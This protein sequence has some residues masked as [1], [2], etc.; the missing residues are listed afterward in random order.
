[1]SENYLRVKK[2]REYRNLAEFE[3]VRKAVSMGWEV[4][5]RGYPDFICY[6]GDEFMLVEVKRKRGYKLSKYQ[7]QLMNI[8][9]H[10]YGIKC[11][12]W[13]PDGEWNPE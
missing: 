6:K 8:L 12:K 2:S 11:Y 4:T 10:K 3:F 9:K 1:M 7:Y 13:T 5:K